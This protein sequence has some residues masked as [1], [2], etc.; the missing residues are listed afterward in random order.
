MSVTKGDE[1]ANLYLPLYVNE[2]MAVDPSCCLFSNLEKNLTWKG[3]SQQA[4]ITNSALYLIAQ[5][6]DVSQ[7]KSE[8]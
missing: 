7:E 6:L 3:S 8:F 4:Y 1:V 5:N 2:V